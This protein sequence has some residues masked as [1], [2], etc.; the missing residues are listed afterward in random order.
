MKDNK[1]YHSNQSAIT[2]IA[3][4]ITIII[5]LILSGIT[6]TL[7]IGD[8]GIINQAKTAVEEYRKSEIQEELQMAIHQIQIKELD[9]GLTPEVIVNNI[10]SQLGNPIDIQDDLSGVYKDYDYYIDENYIAHIGNKTNNKIT[11]NFTKTIGTSYVTVNVNAASKE[12]NIVKYIYI[13]DGEEIEQTT[14]I[15]KKENLEPGTKHTLQVIVIDEKQNQRVSG[16]VIFQ[17]ELRTY[18]YKRGEEYEELTGGWKRGNYNIGTFTK[19]PEGYM[20]LQGSFPANTNKYWNC[21]ET[22]KSIDVTNFSKIVFLCKIGHMNYVSSE[23][24]YCSWL[25]VIDMN[26]QYEGYGS[27]N[28]KGEHAMRFFKENKSGQI[29]PLEVDVSQ[30][31]ESIYPTVLLSRWYGADTYEGN[32]NI[33]EVWLEK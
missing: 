16:R 23:K 9:K 24:A 21:V 31:K 20:N 10:A 12:G 11:M 4:V 5:L 15:Y 18:L 26:P 19:S 8:R 29:L 27:Q 28:A 32:I 1:L 33:Y 13:I 30:V 3:L 7:T 22:V 6:I 14:N 2:L 17:T 25:A